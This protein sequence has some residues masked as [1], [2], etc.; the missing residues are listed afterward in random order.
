MTENTEN[1]EQ[2][3]VDANASMFRSHPLWFIICLCLTP[4]YGLGFVIFFI[5]L[6]KNKSI[7][8]TVTTKRTTLRHGLISK[9]TTEVWHR[10]IRNL[11][12]HQ[13]IIQRLLG[14]GTIAIS[15]AGQSDIEIEFS[16]LK[17]PAG[18]KATIDNYR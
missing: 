9:H 14:V 10:D 13:G 4:L 7:K 3:L 11:Q 15:S 12:V 16:G 5:W 6:L 17:D 1:D 2:T 8:L 18:V